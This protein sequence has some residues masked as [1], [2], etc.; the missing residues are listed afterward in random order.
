MTIFLITGSSS[1]KQKVRIDDGRGSRAHDF[2]HEAA[3]L[4]TL[5][6][7]N[8]ENSEN[9]LYVEVDVASEVTSLASAS[10]SDRIANLQGCL[11]YKCLLV[12][13]VS[14]KQR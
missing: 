11:A 7:D 9:S 2:A 10:S 5:S 4:R 14:I 3:I 13:I 12:K 6:S 8:G 1:S